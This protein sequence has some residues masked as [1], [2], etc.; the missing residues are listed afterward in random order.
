M[1]SLALLTDDGVVRQLELTAEQQD[2]ISRLIE[3]RESAAL[4]LAMAVK[5]LEPAEKQ[6]RQA[7]FV[8]ESERE[9]LPLLTEQQRELL[10]KLQL[11][12]DGLAALNRPELADRLGLSAEQRQQLSGADATTRGGTG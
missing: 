5:Q 2:Q 3:R 1:G 4:E 12:R 8:A 7:E 9:G 11:A 10:S 6:Q